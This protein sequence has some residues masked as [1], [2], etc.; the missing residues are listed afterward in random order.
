MRAVQVGYW[1]HGACVT[2]ERRGTLAKVSAPRPARVRCEKRNGLDKDDV[3]LGEFVREGGGNNSTFRRVNEVEVRSYVLR[4]LPGLFLATYHF[5]LLDL[6]I[7]VL[8]G[9]P[10]DQLRG[11]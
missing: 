11:G 6:V 5:D 7:P 9:L 10:L 4:Y 2:K 3:C 1:K 8:L